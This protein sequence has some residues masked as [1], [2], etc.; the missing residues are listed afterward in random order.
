MRTFRIGS[1]SAT[2][3]QPGDAQIKTTVMGGIR[4][5]AADQLSRV[6]F[7]WFGELACPLLRRGFAVG[8]HAFENTSFAIMMAVIAF[9]QPE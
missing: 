3:G 5:D 6:W 9:G 2:G 4:S 1:R 7:V 8:P